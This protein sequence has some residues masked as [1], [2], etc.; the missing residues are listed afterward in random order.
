MFRTK[1]I[2]R[3]LL[4]LFLSVLCAIFLCIFL[5]FLGRSAEQRQLEGMTERNFCAAHIYENLLDMENAVREGGGDEAS[6]RENSRRLGENLKSMEAMAADS[7]LLTEYVQR[8]DGFRR[9]EERLWQEADGRE[10]AAAVLELLQEQKT[11]AQKL[12]DENFRVSSQKYLE[13][14]RVMD[15]QRLTGWVCVAVIL[16]AAMCLM[17]SR[18]RQIMD[19]FEEN[20]RVARCLTE[21]QWDAEDVKMT[22]YSDLNELSQAIN[23]MKR[24]IAYHARRAE[25]KQKQDKGS[26]DQ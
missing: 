4:F 9:S 7:E 8:I 16:V 26:V 2:V 1:R 25:L 22:P 13:D 5:L 20:K 14:M 12:I 10:A 17:L 19:T 23:E 18:L 15:R 24:E 11:C 6:Y 21:Q 3:E